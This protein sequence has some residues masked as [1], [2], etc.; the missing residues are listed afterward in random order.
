MNLLSTKFLT[1][2]WVVLCFTYI[3]D[4]LPFDIVDKHFLEIIG[5]YA[6]AV[7]GYAYARLKEK[8]NGNGKPEIKEEVKQ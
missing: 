5:F 7:G 3:I 6:G 4:K 8:Q 1:T 2:L